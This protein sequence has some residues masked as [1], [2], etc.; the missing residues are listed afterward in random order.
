MRENGITEEDLH[1]DP[2]PDHIEDNPLPEGFDFTP[3]TGEL[4]ECLALGSS[5]TDGIQGVYLK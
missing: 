2:V 1:H 3:S 4:P 5:G